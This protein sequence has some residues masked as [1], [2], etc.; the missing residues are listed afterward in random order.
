ME[1][2]RTLEIMRKDSD[3][4]TVICHQCSIASFC[5]S[6]INSTVFAFIK[7]NLLNEA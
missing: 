4:L 6:G 5:L 3:S 1:R 2:E 7:K